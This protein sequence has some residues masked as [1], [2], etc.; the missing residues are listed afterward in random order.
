MTALVAKCLDHEI[1]TAVD[2]FG[3]VAK[4]RCGI[5]KSDQFYD[6]HKTFD[7]TVAAGL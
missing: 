6:P 2:D 5:H 3:L 4:T 1:R 7:I